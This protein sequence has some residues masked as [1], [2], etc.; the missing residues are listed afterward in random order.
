MILGIDVSTTKVGLAVID[1]DGKLKT[2]DLIKF[3]KDHTLEEK[4]I[5]FENKILK[6][7]KYYNISSVYIEQPAMMFKGGKTTAFTMAKLQRFNGMCSYACMRV[8][9]MPAVMVHPNTARKKMNIS[10]PRSVKDKK[11]YVINEVQKHYPK[12]TYQ[13]TKFG[14]PKPGTDDM[15]DAIV[16]AY[17]GYSDYKECQDVIGEGEDS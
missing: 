15:A 4:A 16:V 6:M 3:K 11:V 1:L 12:F 10:I 5:S 13:M 7:D 9:E 8:F 2:Y 17:A 14:N